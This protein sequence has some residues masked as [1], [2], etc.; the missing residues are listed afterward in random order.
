[1]SVIKKKL[2]EEYGTLR[3]ASVKTGVNYY[4]LSQICNGWLKP[5][6]EEFEKLKITKEEWEKVEIK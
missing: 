1:M 5:T 4:K 6:E 2:K 3:M